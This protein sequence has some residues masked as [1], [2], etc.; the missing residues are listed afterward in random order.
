[1]FL[2]CIIELSERFCYYGVSGVFN[3]YIANPY[4][5]GAPYT[6]DSLPGAIGRGTA[7]ASGLQ[8]FW[9]FWCYVTPIIGAIVADQFLGR[10]KTIIVFSCVYIVGLIILLITSFPFA[11]ENGSALGGLAATMVIMGLGKKKQ[12]HR[13][14]HWLLIFRRNWW[15]QVQCLSSHC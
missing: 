11:I 14:F 12:L 9:Q 15:H 13:T 6:G 4:S 5:G 7:F 10:Y 8:N 1:M 3:N 2:V